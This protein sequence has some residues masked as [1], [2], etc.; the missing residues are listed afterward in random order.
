MGVSWNDG[1]KKLIDWVLFVELEHALTLKMTGSSQ[2]EVLWLL[3]CIIITIDYS[4]LLTWIWAY[5]GLG[6]DIRCK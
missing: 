2:T 4:I 6:A 5:S 1:W 3:N